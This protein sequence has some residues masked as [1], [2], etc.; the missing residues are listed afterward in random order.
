MLQ[1]VIEDVL[2]DAGGLPLNALLKI[3]WP[4]FTAIDG[5]TYQTAGTLLYQVTNGLV[6]LQL[7]PSI[8]A[9]PA[10]TYAVITQDEA[11]EDATGWAVPLSSIP[12]SVQSIRSVALPGA[13]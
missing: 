13:F 12:V 11:A 8:G 4:S 7:T 3:S 10:F 9:T 6:Y 5:L 1:T 2:H